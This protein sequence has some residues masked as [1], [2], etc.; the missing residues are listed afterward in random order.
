MRLIVRLLLKSRYPEHQPV[1]RQPHVATSERGKPPFRMCEYAL[2][3]PSFSASTRSPGSLVHLLRG[4]QRELRFVR[5][6]FDEGHLSLG[7]DL[8]KASPFVQVE[9]L[10][11]N[12]IDLVMGWVWGDGP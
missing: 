9:P 8:T 3:L 1:R 10:P 2:H 6:A 7:A 11:Q 12:A 5:T 4:Q